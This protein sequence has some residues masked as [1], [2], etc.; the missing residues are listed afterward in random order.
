MSKSD[1]LRSQYAAMA[2]QA[3]A[4]P[5]SSSGYSPD[6]LAKVPQG[7]VALG[8]GCGNPAA[9]AELRSGQTVLDLGSGAG[10]DAFI[11]AQRVGPSGEVIGIDMTPEMVDKANAFAAQGNYPNVQFR[12]GRIE[13]LPLPAAAFDVII[14]N[15]VINHSSDKP[16]VFREAHRVLRP[17]G[18]LL[19][20]DLVVQ[21]QLPAFDSPGLE[22][23]REWLG[24]ACGKEEYLA[25]AAAGG[26]ASIQVVQ[27]QL[28]CGPAVPAALAGKIVSLLLRLR[29]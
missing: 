14:S 24:A 11:A 1:K 6:E 10:L 28:Y 7:A 20:S 26:F 4:V 19:V 17:G 5:A 22:V 21:G 12:L 15:C 9:L 29:K 3:Q 23:W 27:E 25:A 2:Q 8:L 16:A 18:L 13:A